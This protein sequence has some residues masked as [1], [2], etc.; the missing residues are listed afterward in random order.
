MSQITTDGNSATNIAKQAMA[1]TVNSLNRLIG[2]I[3]N[4]SSGMTTLKESSD[5]I[6]SI[7][8]VIQGVEEQTNLLALNAAIEAV[9]R[10][11]E[12]LQL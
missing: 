6:H 7:L 11:V 2:D 3:A 9:D 5:N 4:A 12:D 10:M 1:E 8:E